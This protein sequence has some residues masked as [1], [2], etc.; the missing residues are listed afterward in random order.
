MAWA[1][2]PS[3]VIGPVPQLFVSGSRSNS[4]QRSQRSGAP[5]KARTSPCHLREDGGELLR[6]GA[7][8]PAVRG[9]PVIGDGDEIDR[10]AAAHRIAHHVRV[11]AEEQPYHRLVE[12]GRQMLGGDRGAPGGAM[13]EHRA[14]APAEPVAHRGADAVGTDQRVRPV[15]LGVAAAI[16]EHGDDAGMDGEFLHRASQPQIDRRLIAHRGQQRGLQIGAVDDDEG[17]AEAG[18]RLAAHARLGQLAAAAPINDLEGFRAHGGRCAGGPAR[19][20]RRGSAWHWRRAERRRR[21]L[22]ARWRAPAR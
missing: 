22:P 20:E 1:A 4:A 14:A 5:I 16:G 17:R 19:R 12:A 21:P 6:P 11:R 15:L 13:A 10:A 9:P 18:L 3:S 2:S 7:D 8:A